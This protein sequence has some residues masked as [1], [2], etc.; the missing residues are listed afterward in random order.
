MHEKP[1]FWRVRLEEIEATVQSAKRGKASVIARS[2]GGYPVHAMAYGKKADNVATTNFSGAMGAGKIEP[3][4][5]EKDELQVVVLVG[6]C[7]GAE[8]EATAGLCNLIHLLETGADYLGERR[9]SLYDLA[10]KYRLIVIPCLNPDGRRRS[11]DSLIGVTP[12]DMVTLNQGIWADGTPIGYPTCKM[13]QP[14]DP[15]K[16][17]H[18]GGYPNDAGYNIMHDATPGD[19]RTDEATGLLKLV[20]EEKADLVLHMHTHSMAP[21]IL[22]PNHGVLDLQRKR[23]IDYRRRLVDYLGARGLDARKIPEKD[24]GATWLCPPNLATM[25]S[26]ASGALSP[27][28]EQPNGSADD[29]VDFRTM[30]DHALV[31]VEM[32]LEWGQKERFSPRYELMY[33]MLDSQAPMATYLKEQWF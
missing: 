10:Q 20:A 5:K 24:P 18:L 19:I 15:K 7:H 4:K 28:Y 11:P 3:Y 13:Y 27:V 23:I 31:P 22:P 8:M 32:F 16:V 12:G 9:Q 29:K 30:I 21:E 1:S 33:S 14:L 17:R 2:P 26:L 25:T 6:G